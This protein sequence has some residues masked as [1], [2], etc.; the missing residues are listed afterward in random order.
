MLTATILINYHKCTTVIEVTQFDFVSLWVFSFCGLALRYALFAGLAFFLLQW[1]ARLLIVRHKLR[2]EKEDMQTIMKDVCWSIVTFILFGAMIAGLFMLHRV[3]YTRLYTDLN[4]YG[5][6]FALFGVIL[7][8]LVHDTYFYWLHRL[9]HTPWLFRH[10]H[11]HHHRPSPPTPFTSFAFHPIEAILEFAFIVPMVFIMPLHPITLFV[12]ANIMTAMNVWGHLGY[13]LL[14]EKVIH[15]KIGSWFNSTTHHDM[16][17]R[18]N[19]W[20][21]GL[22]FNFWDRIMHTNHPKYRR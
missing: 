15:G 19:H 7:L 11:L 17:H 2:K 20:N 4:T 14:P 13:E 9:L 3:G 22:Y 8:L 5:I 12:F 10:V 1:F 21:Y 6:L 18:Y 16:H